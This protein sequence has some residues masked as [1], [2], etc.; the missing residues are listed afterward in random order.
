M[1]AAPVSAGVS[2]QP[3]RDITQ[4]SSQLADSK[5][6]IISSS[7]EPPTPH[8][9]PIAIEL[10]QSLSRKIASSSAYTPI[11]PLSA[12]GDIS[13]GYFPFH[14]DPDERIHRPHPFH[15]AAK[16][17]KRASEEWQHE[18]PQA[19]STQASS[20][21]AGGEAFAATTASVSR[22]SVPKP[23]VSKSNSK[24][25]HS[26]VSSVKMPPSRG[27]GHNTPVTSYNPGGLGDIPIPLGKYYPS[28]YEAARARKQG[29]SSSPSR[30]QTS[31][32]SLRPPFTADT[33]PCIKSD[34][35][36]PQVNRPD[37][38]RE[39]S[40]SEAKRRLQQYQRDMV[41]QA[42]QAARHLANSNGASATL[43]S[44][45][46]VTLQKFIKGPHGP[47]SPRLQPLGSP[48]PVTPMDL[49][50]QG[51]DG[52]YLARGRAVP[53]PDAGREMEAI[54]R[55]M[56]AEDERRRR[57]GRSSPAVEAGGFLF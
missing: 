52:G 32:S 27:T 40:D 14:E 42:T 2:H 53:S 16:A 29:Q 22:S 23:T 1:A 11:E 21:Q 39:R 55:A 9:K 48:G 7:S 4:T 49:E 15:E 56:K 28:N 41:A 44:V 19:S 17:A 33:T 8:S 46:G 5:S 43:A 13:G 34:T 20:A 47:I 10:P 18:D 35:A 36:V 12:R 54:A 37:A 3:A 30:T 51:G 50:N 45:H 24:A 26:K 25:H 57:E 31:R 6:T 38:P